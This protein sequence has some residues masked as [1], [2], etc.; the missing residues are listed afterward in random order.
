MNALWRGWLFLG[1]SHCTRLTN[2]MSSVG[3]TQNLADNCDRH[4]RWRFESEAIP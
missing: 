3:Q 4:L 2:A 1:Q